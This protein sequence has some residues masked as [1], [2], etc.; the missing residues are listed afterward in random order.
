MKTWSSSHTS[1]LQDLPDDIWRLVLARGR[2]GISNVL[3]VS[4]LNR[5]MRA[6]VK[7]LASNVEFHLTIEAD[8]T[9][10]TGENCI[11]DVRD[12]RIV[13]AL[14]LA[15]EPDVIERTI[16]SQ[17]SPIPKLDGI[18][19]TYISLSCRHPTCETS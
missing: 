19:E 15:S 13:S 18:S 2:L 7:R 5:S 1:V 14:T 8:D 11:T 10:S 6:M 4:R 9:T 12:A 17:M 3:A 16:A